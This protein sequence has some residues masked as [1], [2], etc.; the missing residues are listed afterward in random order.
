MNFLCS[1]QACQSFLYLVQGLIK[2][3]NNPN[4]WFITR[5]VQP[6]NNNQITT[7]SLNSSG[8]WGM[9]KAIALE[10]PELSCL[11]ID[12]D[13]ADNAADNAVYVAAFFRELYFRKRSTRGNADIQLDEFPV[14]IATDC[15]SLFDAVQKVQ[16]KV[17][18]KRTLID[19][20]S[21]KESIA[22]HGLK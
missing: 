13:A 14:L 11:G 20:L 16:P 8:L 6:V 5:N 10:H 9:Q 22:E 3:A 18:E 2:H 7:K 15:R 19:I 12:I 4:L 17:T 21:L 1:L